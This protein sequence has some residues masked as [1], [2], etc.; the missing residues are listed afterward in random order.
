MHGT[1]L[2]FFSGIGVAV[3]CLV[4][5]DKQYKKERI[6]WTCSRLLWQ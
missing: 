6:F 5:S 3:W 4:Y 1:R 2:E